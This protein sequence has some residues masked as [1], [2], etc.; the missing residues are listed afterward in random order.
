MKMRIL[1]SLAL[2]AALVSFEQLM[3]EPVTTEELAITCEIDVS[4]SISLD[5]QV[6]AC[7]RSHGYESDG[8]VL[9]LRHSGLIHYWKGD[10]RIVIFPTIKPVV[11]DDYGNGKFKNKA[12]SGYWM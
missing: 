3:A 10:F 1:S 11:F 12:E 8:D 2:V 5:N 4:D 7:V 9:Q 6:R